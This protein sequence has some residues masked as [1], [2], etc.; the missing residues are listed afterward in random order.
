MFLM[1]KFALLVSCSNLFFCVPLQKFIIIHS[2]LK[3][4]EW[5]PTEADIGGRLSGLQPRSA[6]N[7]TYIMLS[8]N[9]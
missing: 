3:K 8:I 1:N 7:D 5:L 9:D 2:A 4:V 6:P